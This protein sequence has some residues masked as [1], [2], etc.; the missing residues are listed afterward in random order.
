MCIENILYFKAV[1]KITQGHYSVKSAAAVLGIGTDY[2][3]S[4][5]TDLRGRMIP[6][7]LE[8]KI[9]KCKSEGL[10]PFFVAATAGTTV[11][12]AWDPLPKIA[13]ICE[14]HKIWFH[15]DAAWGG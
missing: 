11:Y 1:N 6:E 12:G 13:D 4:V 5:P 8:R 9:L 10:Y 15:V 2:C 7:A 14:R 3:F